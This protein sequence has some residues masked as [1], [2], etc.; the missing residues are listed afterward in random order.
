MSEGGPTEASIQQVIASINTVTTSIYNI[1]DGDKVSVQELSKKYRGKTDAAVAVIHKM[2]K[3]LEEA[4]ELINNM[5]KHNSH[6]REL[7]KY[8]DQKLEKTGNLSCD[9]EGKIDRV[10]EIASKLQTYADAVKDSYVNGPKFN[11][12][13]LKNVEVI[14]ADSFR[15]HEKS[16]ARRHNVILTGIMDTDSDTESLISEAQHIIDTVTQISGHL[17]SPQVVTACYLGSKTEDRNRPICVTFD[18][19]NVKQRIIANAYKLKSNSSLKNVYISPY[20]SEKEQ[21]THTELVK[22]LRTK[23]NEDVSRFWF[24]RDGKVQS[25]AHHT[26][27]N[28]VTS[29]NISVSSQDTDDARLANILNNTRTITIRR[30]G[31]TAPL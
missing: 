12:D 6:L 8:K 30:T 13:L 10:D 31:R 26:S 18:N 23:I 22:Q 25:R 2:L 28:F 16:V 4:V 14:V 20:R 3:P 19:P 27:T 17:D 15:E 21:K 1:G 24:I 11:S 7:V 29:R 9:L 5:R